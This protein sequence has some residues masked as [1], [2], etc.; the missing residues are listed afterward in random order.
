MKILPGFCLQHHLTTGLLYP[1]EV[2]SPVTVAATPSLS[3]TPKSSRPDVKGPRIIPAMSSLPEEVSMDWPPC[4]SWHSPSESVLC[5]QP[6]LG[7]FLI[8]ASSFLSTQEKLLKTSSCPVLF[9]GCHWHAQPRVLHAPSEHQVPQ[10]LPPMTEEVNHEH[11]VEQIKSTP[12][13]SRA[14]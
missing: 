8:V 10:L 12:K 1:Q 4:W 13:D 6:G 2:A 5:G 11:H 7:V 14:F 9:E 3:P